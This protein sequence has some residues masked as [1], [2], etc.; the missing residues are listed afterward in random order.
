MSC[1]CHFECYAPSRYCDRCVCIAT[2]VRDLGHSIARFVRRAR[3]E[4]LTDTVVEFMDKPEA[5]QEIEDRIA[6]IAAL[7]ELRAMALGEE[8]R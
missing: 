4:A 8:G 7:D 3:V 6:A 5:Y 2:D 1:Y